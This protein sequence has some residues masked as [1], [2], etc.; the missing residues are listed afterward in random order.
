MFTLQKQ[1]QNK[2]TEKGKLYLTE[3]RLSRRKICCAEVDHSNMGNIRAN[4]FLDSNFIQAVIDKI[5]SFKDLPKIL[6]IH[7]IRI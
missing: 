1:K 5:L 4:D 6:Y 2:T 7:K 3:N